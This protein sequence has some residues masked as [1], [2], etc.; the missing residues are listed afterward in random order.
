MK[1]AERKSTNNQA[2]GAANEAAAPPSRPGDAT[3]ARAATDSGPPTLE[4]AREMQRTLAEIQRI[5]SHDLRE[6]VR[7]IRGFVGMIKEDLQTSSAREARE[8]L[9]FVEEATDRLATLV[10]DLN[11]RTRPYRRPVS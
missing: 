11:D 8:L 3:A 9:G 10:Q 6:P 2:N 4:D 7:S 1:T 5:V